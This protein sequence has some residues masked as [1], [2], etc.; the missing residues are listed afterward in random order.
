MSRCLTL[1][2]ALHFFNI[3]NLLISWFANCNWRD[4]EAILI[5]SPFPVPFLVPLTLS[6]S[7]AFKLHHW[8]C[9][10]NIRNV[11]VLYGS[12]GYQVPQN[13]HFSGM[14]GY[15]SALVNY[16][17]RLKIYIYMVSMHMAM[18]KWSASDNQHITTV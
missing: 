7:G 6:L 18:H 4:L 5:C 15:L 16:Q 8:N 11:E 3:S 10:G 14:Y 2:K 17:F 1:L 13:P 12:Y 9:N